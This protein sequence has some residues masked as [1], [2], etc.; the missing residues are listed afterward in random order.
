M[1]LSHL[2]EYVL[3]FASGNNLE[4]LPSRRDLIKKTN[5][6]LNEGKI[7]LDQA[8]ETMKKEF[9][10]YVSKGKISDAVFNQGMGKIKKEVGWKLH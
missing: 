7:T 5:K 10:E 6:D 4:L 8:M 3:A 1:A 9:R 2:E